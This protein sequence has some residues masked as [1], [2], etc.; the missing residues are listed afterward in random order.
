MKITCVD[1]DGNKRDFDSSL[2]SFRVSV[3]GVVIENDKILLVRQ[4]DGYDFPGGKVEISE[5][6]ED[7]LYRTFLKETGL[8][9]KIKSL[10]C[11]ESSF[12]EFPLGKPN[13]SIL[14]YYLCE[15]VSGKLL[16]KNFDKNKTDFLEIPDWIELSDVSKIKF[17]NSIDSLKVIKEAL[18]KNT[19]L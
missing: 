8:K 19:Q 14:I 3:Y 12:F 15:K 5:T 7:A 13:N 1:K 16:T 18:R 9:V 4:W 6:L 10:L 17:Y 2:F 11:C